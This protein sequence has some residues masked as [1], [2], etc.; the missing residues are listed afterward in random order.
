MAAAPETVDGMLSELGEGSCCLLAVIY[1]CCKD[2]D[3]RGVLRVFSCFVVKTA[4]FAV[5]SRVCKLVTV[6]KTS[7]DGEKRFAGIL[8]TSS[9]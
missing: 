1:I 4:I 5:Q 2:A 7:V 6:R 8:N 3:V 9:Y